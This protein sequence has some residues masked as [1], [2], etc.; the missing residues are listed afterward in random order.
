MD[1]VRKET[2]PVGVLDSFAVHDLALRKPGFEETL[3]DSVWVAAKGR[4]QN[5]VKIL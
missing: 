4:D 3:V 5:T 2:K 1:F